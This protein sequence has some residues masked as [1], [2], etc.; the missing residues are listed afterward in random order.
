MDDDESEE[1]EDFVDDGSDDSDGE[2]DGEEEQEEENDN[3]ADESIDKAEM[4]ALSKN[5]KTEGKRKRPTKKW[6]H[7]FLH[8]TIILSF[9][10]FSILRWI[11]LKSHSIKTSLFWYI[12]SC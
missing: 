4:K 7:F 3:M 9:L 5:E 2:E 11:E 1:D 10:S 6:A 12:S 8:S